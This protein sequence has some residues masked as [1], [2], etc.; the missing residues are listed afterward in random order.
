MTRPLTQNQIES[1]SKLPSLKGPALSILVALLIAATAVC[2]PGS[3]RLMSAWWL[4][5]AAYLVAA[6][7]LAV[8][9]GKVL[10]R[11]SQDYPEEKD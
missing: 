2:W 3:G 7:V 9:I 8:V 5:L 10:K 4:C 11:M 6:P 1:L